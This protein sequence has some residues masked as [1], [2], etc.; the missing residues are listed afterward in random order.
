MKKSIHVL[1]LC[2]FIIYAFSPLT[3]SLAASTAVDQS[4][5]KSDSLTAS[6]KLFI[7]DHLLSCFSHTDAKQNEPLV[8]KNAP[9]LKKRAIA[10]YTKTLLDKLSLHAEK[11]NSAPNAVKTEI[12]T[13]D[14]VTVVPHNERWHRCFHSGIAPPLGRNFYL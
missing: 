7:V 3:Y 4:S 2:A 12:G 11:V 1:F 6:V 9:L 8:P 5:G 13:E 10:S 14:I